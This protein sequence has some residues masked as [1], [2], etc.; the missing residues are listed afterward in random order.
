VPCLGKRSLTLKEVANLLSER[1]VDLFRRDENGRIPALPA[2]SPFQTD[3][4][5]RDLLLFNEYFHGDTGLGLG[6]MHQTGWT[7]L[8]ANLV[9]R[10]YRN[11]IPTYW[12]KESGRYEPFPADHEIARAA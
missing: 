3:P 7:G 4:A 2:D 5:W 10:K 11:D 9:Q 6:A 1:L 12:R 8:V